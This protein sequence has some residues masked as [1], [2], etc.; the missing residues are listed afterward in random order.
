MICPVPGLLNEGVPGE[1]WV[2]GQ[3]GNRN[4]GGK[5]KEKGT[6]GSFALVRYLSTCHPG[7]VISLRK[8]P[9]APRKWMGHRTLIGSNERAR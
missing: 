4:V 3:P 1:S 2:C 8:N 9:Q 6:A 5:T 7:G